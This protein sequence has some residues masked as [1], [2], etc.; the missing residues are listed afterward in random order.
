MLTIQGT[1]FYSVE[2]TSKILGVSKKTLYNWRDKADSDDAKEPQQRLRPVTALNGRVLF[3]EQ[4]IIAVLSRCY[5]IEATPATLRNP[6]ALVPA[7]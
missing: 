7:S 1:N 2:E 4:E 6:R 3:R 5:G